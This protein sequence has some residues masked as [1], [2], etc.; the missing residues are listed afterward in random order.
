MSDKRRKSEYL[1]DEIGGIDE[2]FVAE[3][4]SYHKKRNPDWIKPLVACACACVIVIGALGVM[5][6]KGLM[7]KSEVAVDFYPENN[8]SIKGD[9]DESAEEKV[10]DIS[11]LGGQLIS[12]GRLYFH[13]SKKSAL[14]VTSDGGFMWL[15]SRE[16]NFFEGFD[17]GDY[18]KV[19][20]GAVM[21][22]YPEQTYVEGI[23][24]IE[25]GDIYSF[26][27]EEW[28]GFAW[29]FSEPPER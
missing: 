18:V 23:I 26:T 14:L 27:D 6:G 24:L 20:H 11:G 22:S 10:D 19:G 15:H 2:S 8:M 1:L 12:E 17:S 16:D 9:G 25:D 29:I 5:M 7:A 21:E 4:E 13:N 3:A 28:E